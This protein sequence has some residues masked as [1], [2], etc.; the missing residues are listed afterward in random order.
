MLRKSMAVFFV[1]SAVVVLTNYLV[2]EGKL[3]ISPYVII[4]SLIAA[5]VT[6]VTAGVLMIQLF[7][8][9]RNV[10]EWRDV[11]FTDRRY[12]KER[13]RQKQRKE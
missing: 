13:E 8:R 11:L 10:K 7:R 5:M 9:A 1:S 4:P 3:P 6:I 2:A 12:Y